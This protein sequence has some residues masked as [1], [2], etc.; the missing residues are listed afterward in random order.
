M[1]RKPK[2]T[3]FFKL[4]CLY[5]IHKITN[6]KITCARA[7]L[8][9]TKG[10]SMKRSFVKVFLA[11]C[12]TVA[13]MYSA[14]MLWLSPD[15]G[16]VVSGEISETIFISTADQLKKFRD[17]VNNGD[18]HVNKIVVL[19][20]DIDLM[21]ENW[22]PIGDTTNKFSGIFEGNGYRI[23][24]LKI[25]NT[26]SNQG[27]FGYTSNATIKNFYVDDVDVTAGGY[28]GA[29]IGRMS[30]GIV[31]RVSVT[32]GKIKAA[33][34]CGGLIGYVSSGTVIKINSSLKVDS[35]GSSVGGLIGQ[36]A[37]SNISECFSTGNVDA[38]GSTFTGGLIGA[39]SGTTGKVT[40]CFAS[41]Y[42]KSKNTG[43]MYS[44][45]IIGNL[46]DS[47]SI[48]ISNVYARGE[49][50]ATY[51]G[52]AAT[53]VTSGGIVGGSGSGNIS[54]C[55][56][57]S[58][59]INASGGT[60]AE[61]FRQSSIIV[62]PLRN[63]SSAAGTN[64][65][66]LNPGQ[67]RGGKTGGEF[68]TAANRAD[69]N[70]TGKT[71][72]QLKTKETYEQIGWDFNTIWDI[73]T[74]ETINEGLPYLRES[75]PLLVE[76]SVAAPLDGIGFSVSVI[77]E[78]LVKNYGNYQFTITS[79][80]GYT[81]TMPYVVVLNNNGIV[82]TSSDGNIHTVTI[83]N[84]IGPIA[85]DDIVVTLLINKYS[86]ESPSS[87]EGYSFTQQPPDATVE[88]NGS[89]A[90]AID[91]EQSH[92]DG[93]NQESVTFQP[94]ITHA[95]ISRDGNIFTVFNITAP[96]TASDFIVNIPR[97]QYLVTFYAMDE[98]DEIISG[99]VAYGEK[100]SKP[101][102]PIRTNY[103][104]EGWFTAEEIEWDFE[105]IVTTNLTL[106]AK[107]VA[108][109]VEPETESSLDAL[110]QSV[111]EEFLEND[112]LWELIGADLY[113]TID[114][115]IKE[116]KSVSFL[117]Q[118]EALDYV[119]RIKNLASE[120]S[121]QVSNKNAW[122]DAFNILQSKVQEIKIYL[123]ENASDPDLLRALD[124][125]ESMLML[126]ESDEVP[127]TQQLSDVLDALTLA[128]NTLKNNQQPGDPNKTD[129]WPIIGAVA[130]SLI[131]VSTIIAFAV[132]RKKQK[133]HNKQ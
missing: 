83:K 51:S 111:I 124:D 10:E 123:E 74:T 103:S 43:G 17:D 65:L 89:Y 34:N 1:L 130:A 19:D 18:S 11:S 106:F 80:E 47:S 126:A 95:E 48:A 60:H 86:V 115:L 110:I 66:Y 42:S 129:L 58:P 62:T 21:N 108:N 117:T 12:M 133:S 67:T 40:N 5:K 73:D 97:N 125:A 70:V 100:I 84:I 131:L 50:T 122:L 26:A 87:G 28:A 121:I 16:L 105:N 68:V 116:I 92:S 107:W 4:I 120:V 29:L 64:N 78:T 61:T 24:R 114:E 93:F 36:S 13:V 57:L 56:S 54:N 38:T 113:N 35:T 15:V 85:A 76:H 81:S 52:T 98:N 69:T 99:Q 101:T 104:F 7:A 2:I 37:N 32:N 23:S 96:I 90:F 39:I 112:E 102:D 118:V 20:D 41:G 44:G 71:L 46:P 45:G 55:V 91:V 30:G 9:Y 127:T 119:N 63:G 31:E 72:A 94:Y 53:Q 3:I 82:E 59:N 27:L 8:S 49:I 79:L 77:P 109:P 22:L 75:N 132:T 88:H 33:S 14:L 6:N 128:Y 25:D